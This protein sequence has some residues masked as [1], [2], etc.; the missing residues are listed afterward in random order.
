MNLRPV[1]PF[2]LQC[3]LG[4]V[5]PD[6]SQNTLMVPNMAYCTPQ[7]DAA[8]ILLG[9]THGDVLTSTMVISKTPSGPTQDR[10]DSPRELLSPGDQ[11]M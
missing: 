3:C 2:R 6:R 7:M 11:V 9:E 4:M 10:L 1:F 8:S 5:I